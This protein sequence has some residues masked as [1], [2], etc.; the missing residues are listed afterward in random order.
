LLLAHA[1]LHFLKLILLSILSSSCCSPFS[2]AKQRKLQQEL[3]AREAERAG[4]R[5]LHFIFE[6][7][8]VIFE[9]L[10]ITFGFHF[11]CITSKQGGRLRKLSKI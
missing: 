11:K 3:E 10:L 4:T 8:L 9:F 7:L 6:L 1:A 5:A 2:Q